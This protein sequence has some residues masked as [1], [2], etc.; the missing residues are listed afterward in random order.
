LSFGIKRIQAGSDA[1]NKLTEEIIKS[2]GLSQM[3]K[4]CMEQI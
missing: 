2:I 1:W 3:Q 4:R